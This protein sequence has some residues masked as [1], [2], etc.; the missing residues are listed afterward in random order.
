MQFDL[1]GFIK[2]GLLALLLALV[3]NSFDSL[4]V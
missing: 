4:S 2:E 1:E 3:E